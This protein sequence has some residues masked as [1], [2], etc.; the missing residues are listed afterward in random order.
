MLRRRNLPRF[1]SLVRGLLF[2]F[3][4]RGDWMALRW[5]VEH[6]ALRGSGENVDRARQRKLQKK[7]RDMQRLAAALGVAPARPTP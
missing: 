3:F 2:R 7:R 5:I 4:F 6:L 1:L